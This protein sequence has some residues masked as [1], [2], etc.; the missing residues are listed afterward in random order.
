M[1]MFQM[2]AVIA[3]PV[4]KPL[5]IAFAGLVAALLPAVNLSQA[6]GWQPA[7]AGQ[8]GRDAPLHII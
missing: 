2:V 1:G 7:C 3:S 8:G 6:A 4:G 5:A